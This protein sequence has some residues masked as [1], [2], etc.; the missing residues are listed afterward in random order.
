MDKKN[1]ETI[2]EGVV[3]SLV[4]IGVFTVIIYLLYIVSKSSGGI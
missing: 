3:V 2:V 4:I 1:I